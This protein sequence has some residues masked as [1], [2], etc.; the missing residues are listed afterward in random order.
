MFD[1]VIVC[2]FQYAV[3]LKWE[4]PDGEMVAYR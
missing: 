1:P 3:V 2:V 4:Q